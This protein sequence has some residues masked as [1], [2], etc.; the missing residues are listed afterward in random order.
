VA[1]W[2]NSSTVRWLHRAR[3]AMPRV[4]RSHLERLPLP[5]T[6]AGQERA[7]VDAALGGDARRLDALL[8]DAY[9]LDD[10]ERALVWAW[11]AS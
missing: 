1:A 6:T 3:W 11:P 5:S 10:A 7:I 4:L 8:M 2:L 9:R